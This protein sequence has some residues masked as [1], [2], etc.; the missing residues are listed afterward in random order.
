MEATNAEKQHNN[1]HQSKLVRFF[2]VQFPR[3]FLILATIIVAVIF[4]I[5]E[6]KFFST[7]NFLN[8]LT[9]AALNGTLALGVLF[10]LVVGEMNFAVG[11]QATVAAAIVGWLMAGRGVPYPV[12]L[13]C[14]IG[15]SMLLGYVGI[16][17]N[18]KFGVPTFIA[19]LALSPLANG[20]TKIFTG[21]VVMYSPEWTSSFTFLGQKLIGPIP[22]LVIVFLVITILSWILLDYTRLG[23]YMFSVGASETASLQVGIKT[24]AI[25]V[26]GF[27]LSSALVAFGGILIGSR[28]FKIWPTMGD[29]S[30]M[31]SIAIAMLSAT[32][33]RPGRFNVQGVFVAAI[34][35]TMI[36]YGVVFAG[37]SL[38]IRYLVQ[39]L[40][41]LI[42]VG[43]I[44]VTRKGGLPAVQFGR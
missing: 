3:F 1:E 22:V 43:I 19:T 41:F 10:A 7:A 8:L 6:P 23:R 36:Q 4:T 2:T 11:A 27:L 15:F 24:K 26:F 25:K 20:L 33:L 32:F 17:V 16:F 28:E 30:M 35:V 5:I 21:N 29:E 42:S 40:T 34:F 13:I 37:A 31:A 18:L 39:G 14:A 38:A 12:A 9:T 44:A